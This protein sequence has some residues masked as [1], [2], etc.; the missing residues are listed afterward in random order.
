VNRCLTVFLFLLVTTVVA[1]PPTSAAVLCARKKAST[2]SFQEGTGIKLRATTCKPSETVV[3]PVALGLQGPPGVTGPEGVVG[4][5]GPEGP[6]GPVA[7]AA[8]QECP[9]DSLQV[10]T[11]CVD[12]FEASVW[13]IP[14]NQTALLDALRGGEAALVD[15]VSGGATQWSPASSPTCSGFPSTFPFNGNW[16]APLYAASVEGAYPTNCISWFQAEQACRLAGKRLITNQE[17]Q[18]S[19]AGTPDSGT[20]NG[21]TTCNTGSAGMTLPGGARSSCVSS[22]GVHDT[23]GN[24]WEWTGDWT[25][26]ATNLVAWPGGPSLFGADEV[27]WGGNGSFALPVAILRGGHWSSLNSGVFAVEADQDATISYQNGSTV[28]FRCARDL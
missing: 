1:V 18:A 10:G 13:E 7:I 12:R 16:S 28:G 19:A 22:W 27:S 6:T 5:T 15:L 14:A 23:V 11:V 2:G 25:D 4:A 3:D 17:W 26:P 20:D 9:L 24:L 21:S 8:T